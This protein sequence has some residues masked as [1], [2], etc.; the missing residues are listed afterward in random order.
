MVALMTDDIAAWLTAIWDEAEAWAKQATPGPWRYSSNKHTRLPGT[1]TFEEG[2][3]AGPPGDAATVIAVTGPSDDRLSQIDAA[4]I[5]YY[6]PSVVLARI[7]ADRQ[8][9]DDYRQ[10]VKDCAGLDTTRTM[11]LGVVAALAERRTLERVVRRLAS[12]HATRPGY[13]EQW[14]P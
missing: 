6:D 5:A 1:P 12:A 9:L 10:A 4:H 11:E 3:F 2:V 14:R 13:N 7:A 8:I